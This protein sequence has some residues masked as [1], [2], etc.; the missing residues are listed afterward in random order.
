VQTLEAQSDALAAL[1]RAHPFRAPAGGELLALDEERLLAYLAV[2]EEAARTAKQVDARSG[3]LVQEGSDQQGSLGGALQAG[4]L[5]AD[6]TT[7]MRVAFIDALRA[8]R[9]SPREFYAIR[10]TLQAS[11]QHAGFSGDRAP[12]ERLP[13]N[14]VPGAGVRREATLAANDALFEK[15]RERIEQGGWDGLESFAGEAFE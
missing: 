13:V 11:G 10:T 8:Q 7:Q 4:R 3:Q 2:H 9:M 12:A 1:N 14:A 5:L 6:V 15:Y